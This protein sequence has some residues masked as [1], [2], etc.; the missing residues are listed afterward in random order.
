MEKKLFDIAVIGA[1]PGG[2]VAA[3]R[4]ALLGKKVA[5]IEK[6]HLG[7][8]CL[9]D[10]CIPT[11]TLIASAHML[12]QI[13]RAADFGIQIGSVDFNYKKMVDRKQSVIEKMRK[14]LD[15]LIRSH[16]ISVFQGKG[17]FVSPKE[18]K[19]SGTDNLLLQVDH[20][21]LAT[22]S[23]P[24]DI[25]ALP[26]D[27]TSVFDST[28]ILNLD[29]LPKK[30]AI[31][32]GGYIGCEF[33]SLFR[34]L[35]VEVALIE[36]LPSI[37]STQ[38]SFI[39]ETM[40]K[41]FLKQGIEVLTSTFTD[42]I[43]KTND[44]V[45]VHLKGKPPIAADI[46]LIAIGR[47]IVSDT[48]CLEKAGLA[49]NEKG[50][51]EV[52]DEMKTSVDHIYAIGDLTGKALLAHVASHQG[53]VAALNIC[54]QKTKMHYDSVPSVVFTHPEI[55]TVG[56]TVEMA[57]AR[58][59]NIAVGKF[60]FQALGKAVASMDTDGFAQIITEKS[61]GRIL[62][63][64]VIGHDASSLIAEMAL[65]IAHELTIECITE[66]IH[67]HPTLPEAWL[68]ASFV[69]LDTPIHLPP[70]KKK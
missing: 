27:G 14:G 55:A 63:A 44:G 34:E 33:A 54:G 46:A 40:T 6:N 36:A 47:K 69:A 26:V 57:T 42:R 7:G 59:L 9:N 58:G 43:E 29:R 39:C 50:M 48:L 64:Q 67:A 31:V 61:S 30:I 13:K 65:A 15:G 23:A 32:G 3:I 56:L 12:H 37:L 16:G 28:S 51:I 24:L 19:V 62:G 2:Y 38:G 18:I 5:L 1:G 10:G 20:V 4:A 66:T 21:I 41:A 68:E 8:T 25:Q 22:G 17:E 45:T 70:S 49:A 52:N 53:I 35:G 60:P 11:K